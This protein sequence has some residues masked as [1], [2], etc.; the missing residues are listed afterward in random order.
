MTFLTLLRHNGDRGIVITTPTSLLR[1]PRSELSESSYFLLAPEAANDW[2]IG[3]PN[4]DL[5]TTS[6]QLL[7]AV[8]ELNRIAMPAHERRLLIEPLRDVIESTL[9]QLSL[10]FSP[11]ESGA[12]ATE[13]ESYELADNLN[14]QLTTAYTMI[15]LQMIDERA[16][17]HNISPAK[18]ICESLHKAVSL[19]GRRF[20]HTMRLAKPIGVG[21]WLELNQ[22]YLLAEQQQLA[23]VKVTDELDGPCSIRTRFV[24]I[25]LLG[26]C[27]PHQLKSEDIAHVYRYLYRYRHAFHLIKESSNDG[28]FTIDLSRDSAPMYTQGVDH[29]SDNRHSR[30]ILVEPLVT[31]LRASETEA[32][33]SSDLAQTE[34]HQHLTPEV[35]RHLLSCFSKA[36]RRGDKRIRG[37]NSMDVVVGLEGIYQQLLAKAG[38]ATTQQSS[39]HP[40]DANG[41]GLTQEPMTES[42]P[43]IRDQVHRIHQVNIINISSGG[44]CLEWQDVMPR[45]VKNGDIVSLRE[46]G[47]SD[48]TLATIRWVSQLD[49][50]N[51]LIGVS[52]LSAAAV[53]ATA[54]AAD[55]NGPNPKAVPVI[56]LPGIALTGEP[57]G[58]IAPRL[59]FK[60]GQTLSLQC[61][62][63]SRELVLSRL[64]NATSTYCHFTLSPVDSASASIT[65]WSTSSADKPF[66]ALW[67]DL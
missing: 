3:L 41:A 39:G 28:L 35:T 64:V 44:Y 51:T 38:G 59:G 43:S 60:E 52:L 19:M 21:A 5:T 50:A 62:N 6:R 47:A 7:S 56:F 46:R 25:S 2:V 63:G 48:W 49:N 55:D 17:A 58:L 26:C 57:E 53:H 12:S 4:T 14:K 32:E 54:R 67:H 30:F 31:R 40:H 29:T 16:L 34:P 11:S 10:C 45:D 42:R 20:L 15:A 13:R 37:S 61:S 8:W 23:D 33:A 66:N 24:Q 18:V 22:L 27:R 65:P 1:I 9:Q 36:H